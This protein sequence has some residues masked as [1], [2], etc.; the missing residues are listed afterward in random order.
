MKIQRVKAILNKE[1]TRMVK[2]PAT[3]FLIVLFPLLLTLAFGFSFGAIGSSGETTYHIAV[4]NQ[5]TNSESGQSTDWSAHFIGNLSTHEILEVDLSYSL[6]NIEEAEAALLQGELSAIV[7][8]PQNFGLSIDSFWDSPLDPSQWINVSLSLQLDQGSMIISD[9]LPPVIQQALAE[10]I[11]GPEVSTIQSPIT[12]GTPDLVDA[13][14]Y[15]QF[16]YFAP[17]LFAFATIFLIMTISQSLTTEKKQ[18]LLKRIY[19][20]PTRSS[21]IMMGL[22]LSN[23]IAASV[24]TAIVFIMAFIMGYSPVITFGSILVAFLTTIVF[25]LTC[26]GFGLITGVISKNEG[27]ATGI[28]FV[29]IMPMMF[30]GTF[31]TLGEPTWLNKLM[32]SHYVTETLKALFLRQVSPW[33]G[34]IWANIGILTTISICVFILGIVAYNKFSKK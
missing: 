3:L 33:S 11:Y 27:M 8:I 6:E 7:M 2:D 13:K 9:L 29:F 15:T 30:L 4:I 18:G 21:E 24:Q 34:I 10:T 14:K 22:T 28:S 25:S 17:G 19:L 5:D 20:T 31:V 32:P 23:V 16:D 12:L 26:I 1:I